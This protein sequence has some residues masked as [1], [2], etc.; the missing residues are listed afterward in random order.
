MDSELEAIERDGYAVFPG[1]MDPDT[2][3]RLKRHMDGLM[4]PVPAREATGVERTHWLRHP[5]PGEIMAEVLVNPRLLE[6][7]RAI[8][9]SDDLRML[10]QVLVR[11]DPRDAARGPVTP[12]GW[13][14]D[15]TFL[16][17][18]YN[19]RPRQTY[20]HMVQML[21]DVVKGGG[22]T[23]FV[24][25]SHHK[26][27]AA[28]AKVGLEGLPALKA[29]PV[30]VAGIDMSN[31]VTLEARAGDLVVF[32]PMCL[33]SV[34]GNIAPQSRYVYFAS[35]MDAAAKTLLD[36]LG[37][38]NFRAAVPEDVRNAIPGEF[39]YLLAE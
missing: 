22:G 33:H 20:F 21:N 29:N 8:L 17:E 28:A 31:A 26:T 30:E 14:V 23:A 3:T 34:S 2:M 1:I 16:P 7:A 15:F 6:V 13:H 19:A 24:P 12:N 5:I 10:E 25:G 37:K 39:Q 18:H 11:T 38:R 32:N 27:Y 35:F 9:H 36:S 4:P